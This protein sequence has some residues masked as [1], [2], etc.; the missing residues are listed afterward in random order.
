MR[1][2]VYLHRAA[3]RRSER[4]ITRGKLGVGF[5][6]DFTVLDKDLF[7]VKWMRSLIRTVVMTVVAGEVMYQVQG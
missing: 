7:E 2:S 4:Q 3:Q 5:D 1:R 6:A